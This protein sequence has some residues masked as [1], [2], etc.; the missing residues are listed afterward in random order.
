MSEYVDFWLAGDVTTSGCAVVIV[1]V[2]GSGILFL[3]FGGSGGV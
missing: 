2:G 1:L 3:G